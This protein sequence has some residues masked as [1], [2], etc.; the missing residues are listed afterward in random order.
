MKNAKWDST[1]IWDACE[2]QSEGRFQYIL[3]MF[4]ISSWWE[5]GST[6]NCSDETIS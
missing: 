4:L 2:S 3:E 1:P 5:L 6:A